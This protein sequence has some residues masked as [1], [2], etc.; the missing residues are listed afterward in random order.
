MDEIAAAD[1]SLHAEFAIRF[2]HV[3][4]RSAIRCLLSL[5]RIFSELDDV[6]IRID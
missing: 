1:L 5:G 2:F 6:A 4:V 3:L